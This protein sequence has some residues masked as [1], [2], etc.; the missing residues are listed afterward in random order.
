MG[1]GKQRIRSELTETQKSWLSENVPVRY[2]ESH[3]R[4][5]TGRATLNEAVQARC[6]ECFGWCEHTHDE[7]TGCTARNCALWPYRPMVEPELEG[8]P[9]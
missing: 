2:R 5:L 6:R 4:A 1:T 9:T 3:E 7:V 8:F